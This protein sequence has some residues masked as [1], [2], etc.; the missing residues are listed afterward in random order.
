MVAK[1]APTRVWVFVARTALAIGRF[2]R[3]DSF[4]SLRGCQG[5]PTVRPHTVAF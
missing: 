5:S 1:Q 4:L 3:R 2:D